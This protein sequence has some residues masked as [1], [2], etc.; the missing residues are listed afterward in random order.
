MKRCRCV[1]AAQEETRLQKLFQA[2][3]IPKRYAGKRLSDFEAKYQETAWELATRYVNR[4][5]EL[6]SQPKN[7]LCFVGP[8]GTGKTHL[9]YGILHSLAA[10]GVPCLCGSVPELMDMLRP[11]EQN[12]DVQDRIE[13]LKNIDVVVLDD[14]GAERSTDWVTE[15]LYVILNARYS[16]MLPTIVTTNLGMD[17]LERLP[18]WGRIV[19]RLFEMCHLIRVDG[20]DYRK[21]K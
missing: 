14:L 12:T 3:K 4:Y 1:E 19:S 13:I 11:R 10:A 16:E 8:T 7:G 9:A 17:Q 5:E 18:G 6:K 2:A 15:R 21:A 20:A